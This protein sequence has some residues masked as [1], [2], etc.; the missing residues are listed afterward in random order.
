MERNNAFMLAAKALAEAPAD[1]VQEIEPLKDFNLT[2]DHFYGIVKAQIGVP[3]NQFLQMQAMAVPLDV[4]IETPWFSF[5]VL[6]S[7]MDVAIEPVPV[8]EQLVTYPD[9]RLSKTYQAFLADLLSLIEMR[10]LPK[11]VLDRIDELETRINNNGS[12]IDILQQAQTQ[13]WESYAVA[14]GISPGDLAVRRHWEAGQAR[15]AQLE[16][17]RQ[18]QL[19]DQAIIQS[20]RLQQ[21]NDP[22]DQ[23]VLDGWAALTGL[24]STMRYP[25]FEDNLY[26]E[27]RAKFSPLYFATLPPWDSAQFIHRQLVKP[28]EALATIA[29]SDLGHFTESVT[30]ENSNSSTIVTDWSIRGKGGWGPFKVRASASSHEQIKEDFASTQTIEVGARSLQAI[31]LDATSWF[32]PDLFKHPLV[33]K[34]RNLFERYF[35][36]KGSLL[37]YPTHLVMV[38][39]MSLK[40]VSSQAWT[41]DYDRS[42]S[43]SGSGSARIFGFGFGA[44]GNYGRAEKRQIAHKEG[45]ELLLDDGEANIR[46]LG[47]WLAKTTV[48]E[49]SVAEEIE[50]LEEEGVREFVIA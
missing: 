42:F 49:E 20:L 16:D 15:T 17:L 38:R 45:N 37:Y 23:A 24:G 48:F 31:E 5:G 43:T 21:Y 50:E 13:A 32:R 4:S 46:V 1:P 6:N 18:E 29:S 33:A 12:R 35:G 22:Q 34:N 44:G 19:R 27:E 8:S 7:K 14:S 25:R 9:A 39:G 26:V 47:Y 3:A 36:P 2:I 28:E 30:R 41:Y 10:E 40:F 11:E